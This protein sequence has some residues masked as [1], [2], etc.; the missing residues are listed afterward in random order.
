[1]RWLLLKDVRIL[2]RSPLMVALLIG[3]PVLLALLIGTALSRGPDRVAIALVNQVP[4]DE[5]TFT[6][7]G[8]RVNAVEYLPQ[9]RRTV[10]LVSAA[11]REEAVRLVEDGRVLAAVVLPPDTAR[12]LASGRQQAQIEVIYHGEDPVKQRYVEAVIEAQLADANDALARRYQQA[13]LRYLD[14]LLEGGTLTL[15]G[16]EV[17]ILGLRNAQR[18]VG[19][20]AAA[21]PA[22][23]PEQVA[24]ERVDRFATVAIENLGLARDVL[25]SVGKPIT[26]E[27]TVIGGRR[28]PLDRYAV[29]V[30]V[31][32][33]LML[34][35]VL[36][37][38]GLLALEREE[39]ALARLVRGLV[40]PLGLLVAKSVLAAAVA[41]AVALALLGAL[42]AWWVDLD[43]G[44]APL[45]PAPLA[46]GAGAFAA[47]GVAVGA[48]AREVRAASLLALTLALPVAFLALVPS[49][50]VSGAAWTAVTVVCAAFPFKATAQAL[51]IAINDAPGGIGVPLLH[52]AALTA[53]YL[54]LARLAL[55]SSASRP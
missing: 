41:V 26:V 18:I 3:Y 42:A 15:L 14:M 12:R 17:E 54:T 53:A 37:A 7:G 31:T 49:G 6:V 16:R 39:H 44:R 20:V 38:A 2:R 1:M 19:G 29:A 55:R 21:V 22:G 10:D 45:W 51:D 43:L 5:R 36:L 25:R 4:V 34:L 48:V 30:A 46:V 50:A 13:T 24:L 9:L 11:S 28:T 27:Q 35:T 8:E 33:S 47:L 40:S 32:V 23:S 52:L